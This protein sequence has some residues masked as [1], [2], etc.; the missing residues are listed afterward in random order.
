MLYVGKREMQSKVMTIEGHA[1]VDVSR[2]RDK[3]KMMSRYC[4]KLCVNLGTFVPTRE[5]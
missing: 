1:F 4:R 5:T 2:G 3:A